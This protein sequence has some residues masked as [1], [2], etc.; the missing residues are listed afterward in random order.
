MHESA[1]NLG[2]LIAQGDIGQN[3]LTGTSKEY[4]LSPKSD[5]NISGTATFSERVNGTTLITLALDGTK[6]GD[7]FPAHIHR[8]SAAESGAIIIDLDTIGG[9]SRNELYSS[10]SSKIHTFLEGGF[11]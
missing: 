8:N 11:G 9:T 4:T 10:R 5:P 7:A 1:E 3:E 6:E 2:T